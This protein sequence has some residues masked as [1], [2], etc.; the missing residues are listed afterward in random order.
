MFPRK[1]ARLSWQLVAITLCRLIMNTGLRLTYP[2]L[3][4]LARGLGVPL[5][6]VSRLVALRSVTGFF[7]PLMSPLSERLGRRTVLVISMGVFVLGCAVV[8]FWPGYWPLGIALILIGLAKVLYDPAMQAYLG[9]VVPYAQRGKAIAATELA[10]AGAMLIGAPL[11]GLVIKRQG[12][13]APFIWLA[14]FAVGA[15]VWLWW[16]LPPGR[17]P[18]TQ[19]TNYRAMLQVLRQHP[20]IWSAFAYIFLIMAANETLLIVYG[21]WLEDSF[22]LNLANLGLAAGVIGGAELCGEFLAGWSVDKWGKRRVIIITG[23]CTALAYLVLP[24]IS[25]GL[26]IALITLFILFF[27]FELTVVGGVPLFTEIV[28][29]ARGVVLSISVAGFSLGRAGGALIGPSLW[30]AGGLVG[31]SLASASLMALAVIVLVRGIAEP[32]PPA[33]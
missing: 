11:V 28:P 2:F 31:V 32:E 18:T 15:T 8:Y 20:V 21:K 5:A 6:S 7:S 29:H 24:L 3:P 30:D 17:V 33:Q 10:W 25:T 22:Q 9:D 1:P 14:I 19:A 12:W 13:H 23:I 4:E 27:M 26:T 16:V